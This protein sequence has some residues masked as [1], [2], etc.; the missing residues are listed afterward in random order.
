MSGAA[1]GTG[2]RLFNVHLYEYL[3]ENDDKSRF[4][5][6]RDSIN[7]LADLV[8]DDLARNTAFQYAV[9][10]PST[11]TSG[12]NF[13]EFP[14]ANGTGFFPVG[15]TIIVRLEFFNDF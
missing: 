2:L 6:G 7:Y 1:F 9:P 5:F 11:K 13:R 10:S 8:S 14:W 15:K 4:R 12:A 3:R